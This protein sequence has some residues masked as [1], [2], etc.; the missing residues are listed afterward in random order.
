M[1]HRFVIAL[2]AAGIVATG[3]LGCSKAP[4]PSTAPSGAA[5]ATNTPG[6]GQ[7]SQMAWQTDDVTAMAAAPAAAFVLPASYVSEARGTQHLIYLG[8]VDNHLHEL[9][10][11]ASGW[12]TDDLTAAT[13][14]PEP[15]P[16]QLVGYTF[17]AQGTQHVIY[18][19]AS[20]LHIHELWSDASGW[21]TDDLTAATGAPTAGAGPLVAFAFEAKRTQHVFYRDANTDTPHV[22][23]L[24]SDASGWHTEDL[25]ATTG[26]P[27]T[28][29]NLAGYAF[30]AQGTLH[31]FFTA[32]SGVGGHIHEL[33]SDSS[34]WHTD[35]MGVAPSF[36]GLAAYVSEAQGTQHL[37]YSAGSGADNH[38]HEL[39]WDSTGRHT[40]DLTA[41]T[42]DSGGCAATVA[43]AFDA[44][45]TRH[46]FDVGCRDHH[47]HELWSDSTGWHTDDLTAATG[48]PPVSDEPPTGVGVTGYAFAA[49]NSQHVFY[50]SDLD[51][52]IH[53]LWWGPQASAQQPRSST[54]TTSSSPPPSGTATASAAFVGNW[55]VHGADLDIT[56][57][58]ATI[59]ERAYP[60]SVESQRL[61]RETVTF[62]VVSGDDKQLTLQVTAASYTDDTGASVPEPDLP[63]IGDST[64]LDWQAPGLL[65]TTILHGFPGWAGGNPYWCGAGISQANQKLCG[66]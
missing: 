45:A 8:F 60:C 21:H 33:W 7:Q 9:W 32:G 16:Y 10:S 42:G 51:N 24:W 26:A 65:K 28:G 62:T 48:A 4:S 5:S 29:W 17:E 22:H 6:A 46:V 55:H 35:D 52:H 12:H 1:K 30:E 44:N 47:V 61:C 66:A 40:T 27:P 56:P 37:I 57:T 39:W 49:Q 53:E 41:A 64:R 11:D 34:G 14:A 54:A 43:Y 3:F 38:M 20:D 36:G 15:L 2:A 18:V 19:G 23:E 13:G 25:T 31:V 50:V 59:A 58:T 63:A